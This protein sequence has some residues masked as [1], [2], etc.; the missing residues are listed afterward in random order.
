MEHA[1]ESHSYH[2]RCTWHIPKETF[3]KLDDLRIGTKI[4]ELHKTVNIYSA[5]ILRKVLEIL[6]VLLTPN[7]KQ[8]SPLTK[9]VFEIQW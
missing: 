8:L 5:R 4:V 1:K 7:F 6:G 3:K 9:T 2:N